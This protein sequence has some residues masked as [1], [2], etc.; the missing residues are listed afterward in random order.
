MLRS[1][2]KILSKKSVNYMWANKKRMIFQTV[3]NNMKVIPVPVLQDNYSYLVID[4]KT[5]EAAVVD[6][7]EP[8][9]VLKV[10]NEQGVNLKHLITTHHHD[11]HS[12]G[13]TNLVKEKPDLIVYGGDNRIP[14][15]T[16]IVKDNEEFKIGQIDV[17]A[18][19]TICHTS[20]SVS[21]YLQD[22]NDRAVF[23]GDTL[24][25]GGCGRFFEGT[26]EQMHNSLN[27]ILAKL[28]KDTK[29]YCGHEYTKSNLKFA[30]SVEPDN[31]FLQQKIQWANENERTVPSTIGDELNFNPF[32]RVDKES[33]KK[34][35][36]K[37]DPVEVMAALR[38][39]KNKF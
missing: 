8:E 3:C 28:P 12:G 31:E 11:D 9:K 30:A 5:N 23:T 25:I 21:F 14:S 10:A 33:I 13:N 29:V 2:L 20:A 17:K 22:K 7:V 38:E 24:F 15:V 27:N 18:L 32:M 6:P 4:E 36:G 16:N 1:G 37:Q 39:M 35:T 26:A 34:A 19:F